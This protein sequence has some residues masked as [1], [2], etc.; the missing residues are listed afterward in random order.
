MAMIRRGGGEVNR[1]HIADSTAT[2]T[3][4][5]TCLSYEAVCR[6]V[7]IASDSGQSVKQCAI[8]LGLLTEAQFNDMVSPEAVCRLGTPPLKNG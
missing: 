8:E 6:L 7:Q 3:A 1:G 5:L 2:A 4:L